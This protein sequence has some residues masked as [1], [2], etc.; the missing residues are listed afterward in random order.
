MSALASEIEPQRNSADYV[1]T[2][3][4]IGG[5]ASSPRPD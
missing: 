5:F 2:P 4:F 1:T 3:F